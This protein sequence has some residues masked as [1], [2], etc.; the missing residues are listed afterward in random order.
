MPTQG[1][2]TFIK[3]ALNLGDDVTRGMNNT[4]ISMVIEAIKQI[5]KTA[6]DVPSRLERLR[7][8]A[9]EIEAGK[10]VRSC[11]YCHKPTVPVNAPNSCSC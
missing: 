9:R 3:E 8:L 2:K 7:K 5:H 1:Q 10:K 11:S 4:K 6:L